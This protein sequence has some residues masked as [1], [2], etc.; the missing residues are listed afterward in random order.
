MITSCVVT[1]GGPT[2]GAH[3]M[4]LMDNFIIFSHFFQN[5][6]ATIKFYAGFVV[7]KH[8]DSTTASILVKAAR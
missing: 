3:S 7:T 2:I 4:V 6:M 8:Q 5:L 1:E